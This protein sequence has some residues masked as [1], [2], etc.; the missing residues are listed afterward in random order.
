MSATKS[1]DFQDLLQNF[2]L[3]WMMSQKKVSPFTIQPYK[4]TFRILFKYMYEEHGVKAS[5][6]NM[7]EL[8]KLYYRDGQLY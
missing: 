3:K 8:K 1:N 4:D 5:S 2:F 7:E 6:I